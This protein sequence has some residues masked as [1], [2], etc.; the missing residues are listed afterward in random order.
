MN[1]EIISLWNG[2]IP[3]NSGASDI[4]VLTWYKSENKTKRATVLIFP[5]GGY[6]HLAPHEGEGYAVFLNAHGYDAFV[7][8]YRRTPDHFP[9]PLLDARRALRVLRRDAEKFGID[10]NKIA[11]MG[12]SAG[13]HL[14]A[15]VSTYRGRI[16]GEGVDEIDEIGAIPNAT[17]L[18]YPVIDMV[19]EFTHVGSRNNLLGENQLGLAESVSPQLIADE[20]TPPA[21]LMHTA[22]DAGVNVNNS[23][24]YASKLRSLN[25]P[26]EMHV[27]PFG[28]HGLGLGN[29]DYRGINPHMAQWGGLLINWLALMEF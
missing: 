28:R 11:V 18:C 23:Y 14:A 2:E 6:S 9:L 22:E 20:E 4:P 7:L 29:V 5:G 21:F 26:V 15:L 12:S 25:I 13:G 24:I 8:N 19:G 1:T 16:E 17:V 27:F 3:G 10:P